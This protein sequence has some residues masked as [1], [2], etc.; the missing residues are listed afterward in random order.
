MVL[1]VAVMGS[2]AWGQMRSPIS[3]TVY[4]QNTGEPLSFVQVAI[5]GTRYGT[6]TDMEGRFDLS[7]TADDTVLS[8]RLVGY[9]PRTVALKGSSWRR[10]K[11]T[12]E[13]EVTVLQAVSV[14]AKRGKGDR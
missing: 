3:G 6:V 2:T 10:M 5:P 14:T 12:M 9:R 13:P 7:V 4:D 11:V 8:F 1:L